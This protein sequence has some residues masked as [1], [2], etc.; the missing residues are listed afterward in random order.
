MA[1]IAEIV[2][3][4][5]ETFGGGEAARQLILRTGAAESG[6]QTRRQYGGGPARGFWQMEPATE[7]DIHTIS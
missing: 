7:E 5:V 4:V 1:D 6:Y 2:G 3:T